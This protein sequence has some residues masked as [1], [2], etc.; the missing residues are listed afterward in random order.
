MVETSKEW[1]NQQEHQL[2][3]EFRFPK[4]QSVAVCSTSYLRVKMS[5]KPYAVS[6]EQDETSQLPSS[7]RLL[8]PPVPLWA[9]SPL[10]AGTLNALMQS[11][12]HLQQPV[13]VV[14]LR[15]L[16]NFSK[17]TQSVPPL[18]FFTCL[19]ITRRRLWVASTSC[20]TFRSVSAGHS[21]HRKVFRIWL[22]VA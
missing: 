22:S 11:G 2:F 6:P 18:C 20:R 9:L 16:G 19:E 17:L 12:E 14:C 5:W 4:P 7:P 3:P 15:F 8:L 21:S 13:S 1:G 10:L